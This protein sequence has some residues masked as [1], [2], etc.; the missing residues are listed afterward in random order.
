VRRSGVSEEGM[1]MDFSDVKQIAVRQIHDP[2]DHGFI[3]FEKDEEALQALRLIKNNKTVVVPFVPT[4]ENLAKWCFEI[5][6]PEYQ[7]VYGNKLELASVDFF[8]TP[9][10][11]A[12]YSR[13]DHKRD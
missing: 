7:G 13:D 12:R 8:E 5:L 2:L 1:I 3:V 11:V 10:S 4:A 6:D 9:T